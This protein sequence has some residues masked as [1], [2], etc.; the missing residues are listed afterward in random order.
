M[1]NKILYPAFIRLPTEKAHGVQIAKT[2]EALAHQGASVELVV[3]SRKTSI[4]EDAFSYYGVEKNFL[5]TKIP[6]PD[7]VRFGFLG[8]VFSAIWFSE[9]VRLLKSFKETDLI[10]SRDALVL[11][12]YVLLGRRFVYEAHTTP[13]VVSVFVARRAHR[14]V[15][16][17]EGLRDAY[18]TRGVPA[19]KIVVAPDAVDVEVFQGAHNGDALKKKFSIPEGK[20]ITLYVGKIDSEKGADVFAEAGSVG[21]EDILFVV[22]GRGELK[23][24]L[25]KKY[26]AVLFLPETPYALLPEVL[27]TADVL[28]VPNSAGSLDAST[29]TSPLK[30]FAYLASGKPIVASDVPALREVFLGHE[31]V[32]F[33]A[34]G[35]ARALYASAQSIPI[36]QHHLR[37]NIYSWDDRARAILSNLSKRV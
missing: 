21:R 9:A 4:A 10:Y 20:K 19:E 28:V 17:S 32:S 1:Q 31:G 15:V 2:C 34:P 33:F 35:N 22:I 36:G 30:A 23:E 25:Q 18:I 13:S 8:F 12:Q 16:I 14:V 27:A 5:V 7:L 26:P 6:M 29:Y 24:A 37:K 3:P 11:L